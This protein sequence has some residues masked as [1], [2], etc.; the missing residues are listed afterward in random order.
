MTSLRRLF[1]LATLCAGL[2]ASMALAQS[3]G[4]S[5]NDAPEPEQPA[6]PSEGK[7]LYGYIGTAFLSAGAVFVLCKSARR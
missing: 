4:Y 5:P 2:S 6:P 1:A 7:A 3:Q